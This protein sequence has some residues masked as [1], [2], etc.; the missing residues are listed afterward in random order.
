LTAPCRLEVPAKR[1]EALSHIA[2]IRDTPR[3][4]VALQLAVTTTIHTQITQPNQ[5]T[6]LH[7]TATLLAAP[8]PLATELCSL[9][10]GMEQE[11]QE[12][13]LS[14]RDVW[15]HFWQPLM[16]DLHACL[17]G[18]QM[19]AAPSGNAATFIQQNEVVLTTVAGSL[20]SFFSANG[21][22]GWQGLMQRMS[23]TMRDHHQSHLEGGPGLEPHTPGPSGGSIRGAPPPPHHQ[24]S[25][26]PPGPPGPPPPGPTPPAPPKR[27]FWA[28]FKAS[29][30][31]FW[32]ELM[33]VC[34]HL[35]NY[36]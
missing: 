15:S 16:C 29:T 30:P 12:D 8:A 28:C 31:C 27:T 20:G 36:C 13:G 14:R 26:T 33:W 1:L 34:K 21:M 19:A 23:E 18:C 24:P 25:S 11:G 32:V 5:P 9:Y 17:A 7:G 2:M 3:V 22:P 10:A 4:P 35:E 6:R